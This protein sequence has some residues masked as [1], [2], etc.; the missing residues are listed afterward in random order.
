MSQSH[1][2]KN[3]I[4]LNSR[5]CQ[6][7]RIGW[8]QDRK[9]ISSILILI[10]WSDRYDWIII[11][12][13]TLYSYGMIT[14][15]PYKWTFEKL[16]NWKIEKLKTKN[17]LLEFQ[18]HDGWE[19]DLRCEGFFLYPNSTEPWGQQQRVCTTLENWVQLRLD[20]IPWNYTGTGIL[21][22]YYI[23]IF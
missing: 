8:C 21:W 10:Y 15:K 1:N 22:V 19:F 7:A 16:K 17:I 23:L 3:L 5:I 18:S 2:N 13:C 11:T 9:L 6:H 14:R 12:V 4:T 20:W